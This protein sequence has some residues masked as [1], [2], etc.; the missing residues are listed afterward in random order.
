MAVSIELMLCHSLQYRRGAVHSSLA[1]LVPSS[2][3]LPP[4]THQDDGA[5]GQLHGEGAGHA[6]GPPGAAGCIREGRAGTGGSGKGKTATVY[7][8]ELASWYS[9]ASC[10]PLPMQAETDACIVEQ[11][12]LSLHSPPPSRPSPGED[13]GE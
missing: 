6:G 3:P 4:H 1:L 9:L 2:P 5:S 11:H 10:I 7:C 8:K 12:I 13:H